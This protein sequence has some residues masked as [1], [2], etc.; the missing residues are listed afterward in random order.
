[1]RFFLNIMSTTG[2]KITRTI[3]YFLLEELKLSTPNSK[4][5]SNHLGNIVSSR[6]EYFKNLNGKKKYVILIK[7]CVNLKH[8]F[9][10]LY[11][12]TFLFQTICEQF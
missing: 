2:H 8:L 3:S 7:K 11:L 5:V 10:H 12:T 9:I 1:M 4:F 6:C